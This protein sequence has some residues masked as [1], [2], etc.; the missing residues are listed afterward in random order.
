[1]E[2]D[3]LEREGLQ[4]AG[5]TEARLRAEIEDLK[6]KMA[7]L[8]HPAHESVAPPPPSRRFL[9]F[10]ALLLAVIIVV[11]FLKGF[12]PHQ[13]NEATLAAEANTAAREAPTVTIVG[14]ERSA[15]NGSL[16]LP[17]SIEAVTEAPVLA[18]A[19]GYILHRYADIGGKV[20]AGQ[21]LA[22]IDAPELDQ[23]V[24]QAQAAVEQANAALDQAS[25]NLAQGKANE[26]LAKVTAD[27]WKNLVAKGVV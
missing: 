27:R 5:D 24:R 22:D 7:E 13:R 1:M 15:A 19:S 2:Y 17:G 18:R 6:R 4:V 26:Q 12:I 3:S 10:L 16:V 23:Q 8:Q 11:A 21:L 25:A 9:W 20:K 14:V